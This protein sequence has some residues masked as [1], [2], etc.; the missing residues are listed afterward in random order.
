M[1]TQLHSTQIDKNVKII[2]GRDLKQMR[3]KAKITTSIAAE[4]M[5][6]KSRKTIENWESGAS[7]PSINQLLLLCMYYD[8][9]ASQ[10]IEQC[11]E[12]LK[13][14]DPLKNYQEID[15]DSCMTKKKD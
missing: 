7:S 9:D 4:Y 5:G 3:L 14:C 13:V 1:K 10:V 8:F 6:I 12:R 11:M 2:V 15:F